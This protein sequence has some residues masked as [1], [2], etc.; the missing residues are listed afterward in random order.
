MA[1]LDDKIIYI[2]FYSELDFDKDLLADELDE[3]L[4]PNG[5][6]VGQEETSSDFSLEVEIYEGNPESYLPQ[7]RQ[8]LQEFD[9]SNDS[10]IYIKAKSYEIYE[11]TKN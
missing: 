8:H 11:F 7:I 4:N 9:V 1:N 2:Y 3:L 10:Q 6:I 5:A